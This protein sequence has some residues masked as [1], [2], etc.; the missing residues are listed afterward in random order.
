MHQKYRFSTVEH[1]HI[2]GTVSTV[3]IFVTGALRSLF[4]SQGVSMDQQP[5][6]LIAEMKG[7]RPNLKKVRRYRLICGYS[8]ESEE[9]PFA[10]PETLFIAPLGRLVTSRHFPLSP[11]G[12]I[13]IGQQ[14]RQYRPLHE[15]T[16]FDLRCFMSALS[17][18][19]RGFLLDVAFEARADGELVWEGMAA[20]LSRS[21]ATRKGG[22]RKNGTVPSEA[23]PA[24]R[25][26]IAVPKDTGL[27]YAAA[28]GDYNPHHLYSLTAKPLGYQRPIAHGMW[29]LARSVAEIQKTIPALFP[30]SVHASFKL[31]IFMPAMVALTWNKEAPEPRIIFRLSDS[32]NG[33]PHL[34]GSIEMG[35]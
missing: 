13:H 17:S 4:R 28:S 31:P 35:E 6:Q 26:R 22:M 7:V 9:L 8:P 10:Y 16:V 15:N 32:Q 18:T 34:K 29:S 23:P 3:G 27:R 12:L 11:M 1:I 19:E 14:I 20:F 30:Y 25:S 24:E 5:R 33:R 21:R 2:T